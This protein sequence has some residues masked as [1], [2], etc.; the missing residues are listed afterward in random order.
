MIP[1]VKPWIPK[2]ELLM[3]ELERVIYSGY[4][5]QG[6]EVDGFEEVVSKNLKLNNVLSL[7]SGTSALMLALH[8]M[9]LQE[10]DE[11]ISTAMTAEPTNTSILLSKAKLKF[12]DVDST[13]GCLTL[14]S[15]KATV[16]SK[17]KAIVLVH[18]AGIISDFVE[19]G[20]FCREN[21]IYLL[22]DAA[23][24]LGGG[25]KEY[26]VG[27]V[28]DFTIFSLQAIK[29]LTTIDGGLLVVKNSEIFQKA[30]LLRWFGLDKSISRLENNITQPGFKY[31]MNNVNA[32]IGKAAFAD[33]GYVLGAHK[34][35]GLYFDELLSNIDGIKI[36]NYIE[37]SDNTYWLYTALVEKREDFIRMMKSFG[38][39]CAPLHRRNDLH[40]VFS[41]IKFDSKGL[42]EFYSSYIH[43]G[44]GPWIDVEAR[45]KIVHLIKRGW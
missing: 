17:T 18:Y 5:A 1:I 21:N 42:D 11:V 26:K 13:T 16:T 3:P 6:D 22:V 35:N 25:L 32:V 12:A 34:S 33:Y 2:K 23:H 24:C 39:H 36:P 29:H 27:D 8:L 20:E 44:C 43:W 31:H 28:A 15:I 37:G 4:I 30:K 14:E 10:K 41:N 38:V 19:I 40:E 7:N 45:E 9:E